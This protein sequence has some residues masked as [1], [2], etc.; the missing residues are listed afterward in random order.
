MGFTLVA[1]TVGAIEFSEMP[2]DFKDDPNALPDYLNSELS[3]Y[4]ASGDATAKFRRELI[5]NGVANEN[6][7]LII[8]SNTNL[9]DYAP[10]SPKGSDNVLVT[11]LVTVFVLL[12]VCCGAVFTAY[13][14]YYVYKKEQNDN[15]Q[16]L[17]DEDIDTLEE[18]KEYDLFKED[19]IAATESFCHTDIFKSADL[20]GEEPIVTST[21]ETA[22]FEDW[23]TK[24]KKAEEDSGAKTPRRVSRVRSKSNLSNQN[25]LP[26]SEIGND[27]LDIKKEFERLV[28]EDSSIS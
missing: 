3:S 17:H 15:E 23:Q 8:T 4:I 13:W 26:N 25:G 2:T 14:Y 20:D 11:A 12:F 18:G 10:S 9:K 28:L 7:I 6:D 24:M 27:F 21:K 19:T 5:A 16:S 22:E 1:S